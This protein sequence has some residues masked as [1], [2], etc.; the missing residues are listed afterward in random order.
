TLPPTIFRIDPS[1]IQRYAEA[2]EDTNPL[3]INSGYAARS[4]HGALLCPPGFVGWPANSGFDMLSIN[5]SLIK[6]GAPHTVMDGGIAYEFFVPIKAGDLLV[7]WVQVSSIEEKETKSGVMLVVTI[8]VT[9]INQHGETAVISK[10]N[11][12]FR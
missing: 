3:F 9:F 11:L 5:M 2:I 12:L 1:A 10:G 8:T 7:S 6:A 4:K